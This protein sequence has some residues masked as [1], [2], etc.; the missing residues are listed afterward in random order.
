MMKDAAHRLLDE[1]L[2]LS[3]RERALL[4][5]E[6]L[7][8]LDNDSEADVESA[9]AAEIENRAYDAVTDNWQGETWDS[10]REDFRPKR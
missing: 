2:T 10:I 3:P 6:L 4:A 8:T 7:A 1:A 9:W 5:A